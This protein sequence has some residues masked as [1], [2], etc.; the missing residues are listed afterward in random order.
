MYKENMEK[1]FYSIKEF[2]SKLGVSSH[3]IRRSIK[4]GRIIG[5]RI[6]SSERSPFR[7]PHSEIERIIMIDLRKILSHLES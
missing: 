3:T 6:G 5:F 4:S 2:A 7:I 1:D